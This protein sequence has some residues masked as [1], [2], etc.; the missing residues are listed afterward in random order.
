MNRKGLKRRKRNRKKCK[1]K[2]KKKKRKGEKKKEFERGP[3][4]NW[5]L[6]FWKRSR[7]FPKTE[8]AFLRR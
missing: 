4:G 2:T 6:L 8:V 1:R 5:K 3:L 7:A